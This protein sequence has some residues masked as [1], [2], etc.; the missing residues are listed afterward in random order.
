MG[1]SDS[2]RV[3]F[4]EDQFVIISV[5]VQG[6]NLYI[7][8]V[9]ASTSYLTR[10]SLWSRLHI[11]VDSLPGA[12]LF[13]GD[14]NAVMGAHEKKGGNL[15][16]DT[17]CSEFVEWINKLCLIDIP[18]SG[19]FYTWYNGLVGSGAIYQRLDRCLGNSECLVNWDSVSCRTLPR[20]SS[21]HH[22]ILVELGNTVR[23]LKPNLKFHEM[24][25]LHQDCRAVVQRAWGYPAHGDAMR[26]LF[27]KL[28]SVKKDLRI[29]NKD[30]FGNV[31]TRVST[32]C[33]ALEDVQVNPN[34]SPEEELAAQRTLMSE[35]TLEEAFWKEKVRV[36]WMT[37]SDRNTEFFFNMV[38]ARR[39]T[40]KI[41]SLTHEGVRAKRRNSWRIWLLI[42]FIAYMKQILV[43]R[44]MS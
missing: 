10:R 22:P 25:S 40:N 33:K 44:T 28:R 16:S 15:P 9:Y 31:H 19:S 43:V 12:W 14:F 3:L 5:Q 11:I 39:S 34:H 13:V 38:K 7:A 2:S 27:F 18:T 20:L 42:S 21:D 32:T 4:E 37:D 23:L 30:V 6:S 35:L 17:S 1:R 29:W 36:K 8:F 24:W 41:V 26:I